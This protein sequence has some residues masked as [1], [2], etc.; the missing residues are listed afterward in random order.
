M[1]AESTIFSATRYVTAELYRENLPELPLPVT[2]FPIPAS[3]ELMTHRITRAMA[4]CL[5]R[6]EPTRRRRR[7]MHRRSLAMYHPL[8]G[9]QVLVVSTMGLTVITGISAQIIQCPSMRL[10]RMLL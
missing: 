4:V 1:P 2:Q 5:P 3:T 6:A 10:D 8:L 9:H 7:L